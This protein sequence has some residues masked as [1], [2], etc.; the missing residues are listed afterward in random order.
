MLVYPLETTLSPLLK[1]TNTQSKVPTRM[2]P[3]L[4]SR[5]RALRTTAALTLGTLA[6]LFGTSSY[7]TRDT[8]FRDFS[9][10]SD[11]LFST[12]TY[13]RANPHGNDTLH[14]LCVRRVPLGRLRPELREDASR[15]GSRLVREFCRGAWGGRGASLAGSSLCLRR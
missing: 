2:P 4:L 14:D 8:F 11:S 5:R 3:T 1:S 10:Q 13:K 15:G 9:P 6:V 7:L 12:D